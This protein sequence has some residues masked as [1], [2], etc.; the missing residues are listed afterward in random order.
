MDISNQN[1]KRYYWVKLSQSFFDSLEVSRITFAPDNATKTV[2][3]IRLIVMACKSDGIL[4]DATGKKLDVDEI[5]YLFPMYTPAQL[6]DAVD[7][8][9]Q[10]GA[11]EQTDAGLFLHAAVEMVD[12]ESDSAERVRKY[13]QRNPKNQPAEKAEQPA[14]LESEPETEPAQDQTPATPPEPAPAPA[15]PAPQRQNRP[16]KKDEQRKMVRDR[17]AAIDEFNKIT[18]SKYTHDDAEVSRLIAGV[19]R[20]HTLD[21]IKLVIRYQWNKYSSY[22]RPENFLTNVNPTT[23]S[24][25]FDKYL[26]EAKAHPAADQFNNEANNIGVNDIVEQMMK[27]ADQ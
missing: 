5:K 24:R 16:P 4:T 8:L 11:I 2:I 22:S 6:S 12:S 25:Y 1:K 20:T 3:Y 18:G 9:L 19:L 10:I 14:Q 27:E 17:N 15:E 26:E 21:D 7:F 23:I 13:R